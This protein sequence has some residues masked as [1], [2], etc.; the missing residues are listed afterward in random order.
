MATPGYLQRAELAPRLLPV[1]DRP[2]RHGVCR[3]QPVL[4]Q[5]GEDQGQQQ[6]KDGVARR[7]PVRSKD[8]LK[9]AAVS[10]LRKLLKLPARVQKYFEHKAVRYAA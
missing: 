7:A 8:E 4:Q 10:Y 9:K 2:V 3:R 1:C 5:H 6:L